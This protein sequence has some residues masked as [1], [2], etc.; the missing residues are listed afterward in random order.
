MQSIV[1]WLK[2]FFGFTLPAG[3]VFGIPLRVHLLVV[4]LVAF[5]AFQTAAGWWNYLG[6]LSLVCALGFVLILYGSILL[7]ELGHAWGCRL[8][9]G[10]TDYIL[11]WPLGGLHVGSGGRESPRSELIV[12]ALGPAVSIVLALLGFAIYSVVPLPDAESGRLAWTGSFL[13]WAFYSINLMLTLFNLLMVMF[14]LDSGRLLRAALSLKYHPG[15]ITRRVCQ[16]S[17][18]FAIVLVMVALIGFEL[19]FFGEMGFWAM[20]IGVL[21]IG[22]SL[23]ELENL[24][25]SPV[26]THADDWGRG[27]V[28][29][30][31]DLVR[32]AKARAK[33]DLSSI[34]RRKRGTV[35]RRSKPVGPA[36]V[37]EIAAAR[38]PK[39]IDDLGELRSMMRTAAAAEDF[40][41]A[42]RIKRRIRELETAR[43]GTP[44]GD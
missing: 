16:W 3:R 7:H 21:A 17:I 15:R 26:Y 28:Y 20:M 36:A 6:F 11:L 44:A 14:P 34:F 43:A 37:I 39:E 38:D 31:S 25:H 22:V 41:R 12:V 18:G 13:V 29:Y 5:H 23:N 33:E 10:Q 42:A 27:P 9:G 32:G 2:W 8:V 1:R 24:K 35:V 19:P 30:D 40:Q 4:I